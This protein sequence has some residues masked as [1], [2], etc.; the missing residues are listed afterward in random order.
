MKMKKYVSLLLCIVIA[1]VSLVGCE[2]AIGQYYY[3]VYLPNGIG[4][5]VVKTNEVFDFYIITE[6]PGEDAT[7][8]DI[9]Q[10]N[11]DLATI[12]DNINL[13]LQDEYN[14][15]LNIIFKSVDEYEETV[16]SATSGIVLINSESLMNDLMQE[17]KLVDLTNFLESSEY[18]YGTLNVQ[19]ASTLLD[20]AKI[21]VDGEK[22][23]YCIPNNHIVG[24]Y[25]YIAVNNSIA[26]KLQYGKND[27][28]KITTVEAAEEFIA[29]AREHW[30]ALNIEAE[31]NDSYV[32]QYFDECSYGYE[33]ETAP[34]SDWT[35][36]VRNLPVVTKAEAYSTAYGILSGTTAPERAMEIIYALN[37][38][39]Q[40]RNL[41]QYGVLNNDYE[42]VNNA[43][44]GIDSDAI[45][46]SAKNTMYKMNLLYT[47]DVF[48]AYYNLDSWTEE[49]ALAGKMQNSQSVLSD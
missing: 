30:D 49:M 46:V 31:F 24:S 19:I 26:A 40:F 32:L 7:E 5:P 35:Y 11:S 23:L 16:K 22:K 41:L 36:N 37:T 34:K 29:V 12:K 38:D 17:S 1:V 8:E 9:A 39:V 21:D 4:A 2:T 47:G 10:H 33:G 3:D 18:E 14:T 42:F 13:H 6:F 27:I 20:A 48:M 44:A 43:N 28:A 25:D 45:Y 15:K